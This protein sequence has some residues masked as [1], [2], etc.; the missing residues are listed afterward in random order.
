M[1]RSRPLPFPPEPLAYAGIQLTRRS[2]AQADGRQGERNLL[3]R[4]LDRFGLGYDS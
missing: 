3:L 4:T 1:V 2:L